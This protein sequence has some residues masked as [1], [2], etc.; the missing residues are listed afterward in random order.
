MALTSRLACMRL[1]ELYAH[2]KTDD[3]RCLSA[4]GHGVTAVSQS[5]T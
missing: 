2:E 5:G 3:K 4:G 1:W